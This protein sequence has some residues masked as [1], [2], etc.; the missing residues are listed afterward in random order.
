MIRSDRLSRIAVIAISLLLL[1]V[2]AEAQ[3]KTNAVAGG[4]AVLW[5]PVDVSSQDLFLGSGG[6]RM[7]PDLSRITFIQE[8][9]GGYSKKYKIKDG[10]GRTWVAKIG[11]EAQSE[12][13]AVR[14]L[15]ALGY[16]TEIVYLVPRMTIPGKGTFTNVRL[17]ARP[18]E[19]DRGDVWRWSRNPFV[20]TDQLQGLK[21][22]M[23]MFNNWDMKDTNNVILNTR[24][25]QN[26]VVSDLGATFG[27][28]GIS[29]FPLLRW[30]G[31]SRNAPRDYS[32]A[33]FISGV[34]NGRVHFN[35]KG[36]NYQQ[37]HNISVSQA[38]WLAGLLQQLS[39]RQIRDAFRAANYPQSDV[40]LLASAF[41]DRIEQLLQAVSSDRAAYSR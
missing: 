40:N 28:T 2:T 3:R 4:R 27:K 41:N 21:I 8:Q 14:L 9:K 25:R 35:F 16:K 38:R 15:A 39:D 33:G 6:T 13:A 20:G 19:V 32:K 22:M 24:D 12:T 5:E 1:F 30:I 11:K 36:K 17:E 26:Y 34:K 23:A 29:G 31:R 7:Q 18:D 10:S 37:L